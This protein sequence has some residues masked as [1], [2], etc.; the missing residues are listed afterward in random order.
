[1]AER[2]GPPITQLP[3]ELQRQLNFEFDPSR[4]WL[5]NDEMTQ[6]GGIE[7]GEWLPARARVSKDGTRFEVGARVQDLEGLLELN[8]IVRPT[9]QTVDTVINFWQ[10]NPKFASRI[11]NEWVYIGAK[12]EPTIEGLETDQNWDTAS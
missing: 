3:A 9:V 7:H 10:D 12:I 1:M 2:L 8:R 4:E 11:E 6:V 5:Q